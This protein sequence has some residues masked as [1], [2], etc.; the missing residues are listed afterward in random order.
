M[1]GYDQAVQAAAE[2]FN[3]AWETAEVRYR[4]DHDF[5]PCGETRNSSPGASVSM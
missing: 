5:P 2:A 3:L 1:S 4:I